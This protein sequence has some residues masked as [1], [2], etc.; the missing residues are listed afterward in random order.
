MSKK[1]KK[2]IALFL[3]INLLFDA[4]FPTAALA[5]GSGP[6][7]PEVQAFTPIGTSDM[8][9]AFTG[10]FNYNIPLLDVEGYPVN[11]S[12]H[13]GITSDQEASWVG[14]GWNINPG[15]INR[16][17]RSLPDEFNGED[18]VEKE[19]NMKPNQTFGIS[20]SKNWEVI[21]KKI[22]IKKISIGVK[23]SLSLG[24]SYNT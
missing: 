15:A 10:D 19:L 9:N 7:N 16:N 17:M 20:Y 6:S 18:E 22:K 11:L 4:F 8:V 23:P 2:S 12:Y 13:A 24:L 14:L 1:I 21:G 3:A 5:L